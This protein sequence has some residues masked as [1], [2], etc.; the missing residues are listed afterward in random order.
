[1]CGFLRGFEDGR[2]WID[3]AEYVEEG[4]AKRIKELRLTEEELAGYM[5]LS[6]GELLQAVRANTERL[7]GV[8]L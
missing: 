5:K 7:F 3:F 6:E 1:M 2:V 8:R 4:D